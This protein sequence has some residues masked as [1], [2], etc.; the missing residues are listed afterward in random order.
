MPAEPIGCAGPGCL[1]QSPA[2]PDG[3]PLR[4][5]R[6]TQL[7][8]LMPGEPADRLFCSWR[9][10]LRAAREIVVS[11]VGSDAVG[12]A[13]ASIEDEFRRLLSGDP[14]APPYLAVSVADRLDRDGL[15]RS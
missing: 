13:R 2:D 12:L 5:I 11:D 9:C 15:L 7:P 10:T 3:P 14:Q 6:V 8:P 1:V 4:W